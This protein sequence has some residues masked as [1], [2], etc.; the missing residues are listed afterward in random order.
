MRSSEKLCIALRHAAPLKNAAWLWNALRPIYDRIIRISAHAGLERVIN[1]TDRVLV[2]PEV[3]GIAETYEPEVWRRVMAQLQS[4][5][6]L[7]EEYRKA[8]ALSYFTLAQ[9]Y[10]DRDQDAFER[11][12]AKVLRLEPDFTV[13]HSRLYA[14]ARKVLGIRRAEALASWRRRFLGH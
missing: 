1:G 5:G 14:L 4:T 11:L 6:R 3:R 2:L 7:T 9:N 13:S 12:I 10:Y 8:L